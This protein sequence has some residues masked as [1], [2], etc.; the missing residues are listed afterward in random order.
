MGPASVVAA[1]AAAVTDA[2]QKAGLVPDLPACRIHA[3]VAGLATP[4]DEATLAA[5]SHPFAFLGAQSDALLALDAYFGGGPGALL[6]VGTGCLA[7]ARGPD[8]RMH[9]RRG[10][11]FPLEEGGGADL[12]LRALRLGL[13]DWERGENSALATALQA[14]FTSPRAVMEWARGQTGGGY[15]RFAPP[16]FEAEDER[17]W[18]LVEEWRAGCHELALELLRVSG[19][20][21]LGTWGGLAGLLLWAAGE[22][23]WRPAL[24]TSLRWAARQSG[25]K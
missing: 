12:G 5:V 3:G 4:E 18:R 10:W 9:R 25:R 21:A 15:A 23:L 11:G 14:E 22:P 6:I 16:L 13:G 2:F 1:L 19:A 24:H 7:L 20:D 8:G 17:A